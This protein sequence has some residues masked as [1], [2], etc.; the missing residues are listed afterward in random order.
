[1]KASFRTI[2]PVQA[3]QMLKKNL[4][5]NRD[6]RGDRVSHWAD[7]MRKGEWINSHQGI[8]FDT[9]GNL[10]DGQHRLM[11]IVEANV[12]VKMMVT[13]GVPAEVF[14]ICDCGLTRTISDRTNIPQR[15]VSVCNLIS[16]ITEKQSSKKRLI[17]PE[18]LKSIYSSVKSDLEELWTKGSR[19]ASRGLS[20]SHIHLAAVLSL[21]NQKTKSGRDFVTNSYR[22]L[23]NRNYAELNPIQQSFLKQVDGKKMI[24][25]MR[26]V[27][28]REALEVVAKG[29]KIFDQSFSDRTRV[30]VSDQEI[31]AIEAQIQKLKV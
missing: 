31:S 14:Q 7:Q 11:A 23:V 9:N 28:I 4:R 18:R 12:S 20:T 1:M 27:T 17:S 10:C 29:V 24:D 6:V 13:H 16:R 8:A 21:K 15:D 2:T 3:K 30:S 25:G 26:N 19:T 5:H 22:N